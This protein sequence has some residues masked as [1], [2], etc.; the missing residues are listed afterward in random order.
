MIIKQDQIDKVIN[1]ANIIDVISSY[2][3][4]KK[5]GRNYVAVCPFHDDSD[6]SLNISTDKKIFKCFVCGTGGNVIV[7][8]QEFNNVS[9]FEA[10]KILAD[11]LKIKITG[12]KQYENKK[13]LSSI[14]NKIIDINNN[15]ASLFNGLLVSNYSKFAQSYLLKRRIDVDQITK[16]KIGFCPK[17]IN[18]HEYL[19]KEG[20][21]ENV[22]LKSELLYQKGVEYISFFEDRLV[23]PIMDA[24]SNIIGFSGRAISENHKPKYKNS[25]D[26][27]VFK[28]S[29]LAYNF[30]NA[31]N[32]IRVNNEIIILEGFMDVIS[33]D[34]IGINNC[35]AIMGTSLSDFHIKLFSSLSKNYKLFLDNDNAGIQ[36]AYK[37]TKELIKKNVN[38]SIVNNDSLKDPDEL[39]LNN[40]IDYIKKIIKDAKHP[41]DYFTNIFSKNLNKNDS[42]SLQD[43]IDKLFSIIK[44]E[45]DS[46]IVEKALLNISSLTELSIETLQN[47][48]KEIKI[49][50]VQENVKYVTNNY[51]PS[52]QGNINYLSEMEEIYYEYPIEKPK[53]INSSYE[54]NL[55]NLIN[56]KNLAEAT[57]IWNLLDSKRF[58]PLIENNLN[59]IKDYAV[60]E[61]LNF[62]IEEYKTNNY[63][64]NDWEYIADKIKKLN[65]K[66]CEKIYEIKNQYFTILKSSYTEKAVNDCFDIIELY[67]IQMEIDEWNK[68]ITEC[69]SIELKKNYLEHIEILREV[70]NIIYQKRRK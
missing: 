5:R 44:L 4:V 54:D 8:I 9:F 58:I 48:L 25:K 55:R 6:P 45:K 60:V 10:I 68:K 15:V 16:Y 43:F 38:L 14:E 3:D 27:E 31:K 67:K 52:F 13:N 11:Q 70:R 34:R 37:I 28:K 65:V 64:G 41:I 24:D 51:P 32:S 63:L 57:I 22:I 19:I 23:F 30:N 20:F 2:I 56:T 26:N 40:K 12:I 42:L 29:N 33:L 66:Y 53:T 17:E 36:A 69:E 7:F 18:L 35:V 46:I 47:K 1:S 49:D 62:I 39:V 61:I 59:K 50:D 21:D